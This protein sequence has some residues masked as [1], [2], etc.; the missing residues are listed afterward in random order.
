MAD[1]ERGEAR[2][3]AIIKAQL[4]TTLRKQA[5]EQWAPRNQGKPLTEFNLWYGAAALQHLADVG[6]TDEWS[7]LQTL[8]DLGVPQSTAKE[9]Y[10]RETDHRGGSDSTFSSL[11]FPSSRM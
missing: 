1:Y 6:P 7:E 11:P 8:I 2:S 9:H 4:F 10:K 5:Y 3:V